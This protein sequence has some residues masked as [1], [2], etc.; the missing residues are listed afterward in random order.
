MEGIRRSMSA[1]E[2]R[3]TGTAS[4]EDDVN[5]TPDIVKGHF[6]PNIYVFLCFKVLLNHCYVDDIISEKSHIKNNC[7]IHRNKTI[8]AQNNTRN[9]FST[10]VKMLK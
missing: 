2:L 3:V 8:H 7:G 9:R 6:N 4:I 1:G 5:Y 10:L